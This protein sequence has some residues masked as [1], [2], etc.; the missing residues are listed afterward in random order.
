M[1]HA[2]IIICTYKRADMLV[3]A[4][5]SAVEQALDPAC[6]ETIVVDNAADAETLRV[7]RSFQQQYPR[8]SIRYHHEP[9]LGLGYARNAG[10]SQARGQYVA[11]LDDDA[12]ATPHWLATALALFEAI[13]PTPICVGG[14]IMPFYQEQKPP[15]FK[16]AYEIRS[17]G[18]EP[19]FLEP[20]E[21]FSGSNMIWLCDALRAYQGFEVTMGVKGERLA[22]GEES[23]LFKRIGLASDQTPFFYSPR[24]VVRHWVPAN[25]M[26][27][28]YRLKRRFAVGQLQSR[29]DISPRLRERGLMTLKLVGWFIP[30]R[31]IEALSRYR[32]YTHWQNWLIEEFWLIFRDVGVVFGMWRVFVPLS[33]R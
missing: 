17:W 23:V 20:G 11:Y 29:R 31:T 26:T 12:L 24:L 16:D 21:T 10:L 27:V 28:G 5:Q 19:R 1:I 4:L 6:Y 14:V 30:K 7:V 8:W 32:N 3:G 9:Q 13:S 22:L 15:W 33:Q 2:S 25:K 18:T